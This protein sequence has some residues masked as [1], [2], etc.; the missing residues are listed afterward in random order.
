M[1]R[2]ETPFL[3]RRE[4]MVAWNFAAVQGESWC[5]TGRGD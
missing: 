4:P 5:R 1:A 2:I 3:H